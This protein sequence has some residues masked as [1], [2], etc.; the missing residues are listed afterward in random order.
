MLT[1]LSEQIQ[2]K[3]TKLRGCCWWDGK[4][5]SENDKILLVFRNA[6]MLVPLVAYCFFLSK[7]CESRAE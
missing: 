4:V 7:A 3:R 6:A 5:I 2:K 1:K